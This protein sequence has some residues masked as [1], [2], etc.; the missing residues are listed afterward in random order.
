[1]GDA[2]G[3]V[4]FV[5][6]RRASGRLGRGYGRQAIKAAKL[7]PPRRLARAQGEAIE[8]GGGAETSGEDRKRRAA[9]ER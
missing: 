7:K 4:V 3:F 9:L 5:E 6:C 8:E 1:V 2:P